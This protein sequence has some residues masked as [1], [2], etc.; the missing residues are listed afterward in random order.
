MD[1][2]EKILTLSPNITLLIL[3]GLICGVIVIGKNWQKIKNAADTFYNTRKKN[4]KYR[5]MLIHADEKVN[6]YEETLDE[7]NE[8]VENLQEKISKYNTEN[9]QHWDVSIEYRKKYDE[10]KRRDEEKHIEIID[11]QKQ[12]ADAQLNLT[13]A[14][15]TL[16]Q[17][18]TERE[19][20]IEA[21]MCACRNLL[22]SDLNTRYQRYLALG[23]VPADEY[24][25]F[26]A[27]YQ[28]YRACNGNH[29]IEAKYKY[30]MEHIPVK[31]VESRPVLQVN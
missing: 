22:A 27:E 4:E 13:N 31:V 3:F 1:T 21:L 9:H 18:S 6:K 20:K 25:E 28:A 14:V 8:N 2:V 30:I 19:R 11:M 24:D 12:L 16:T 23:Y 17:M 15:T 26:V 10:Q 5:E 7:L 29:S